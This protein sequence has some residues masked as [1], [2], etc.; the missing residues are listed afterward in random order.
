MKADQ[1][2]EHENRGCPPEKEGQPRK[3]CN[4]NVVSA[5]F[6]KTV[7][8]DTTTFHQDS[9]FRFDIFFCFLQQRTYTVRQKD[10]SLES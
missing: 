6:K 10:H 3:T 7:K 4:N 9:G 1:K 2:Y 5:N 8:L